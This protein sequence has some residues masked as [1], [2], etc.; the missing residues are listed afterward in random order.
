MEAD[1]DGVRFP[2]AVP[3]HEHGVD[4]HLLGVRDLHFHLV[5]AG[6]EL[7]ADLLCAELGLEERA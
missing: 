2:V 3:D 6:V 1:A 4:F 7:A 5:G